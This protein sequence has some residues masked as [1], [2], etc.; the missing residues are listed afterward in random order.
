MQKFALY[1]ALALCTATKPAAPPKFIYATK[2]EVKQQLAANESEKRKETAKHESLIEKLHGLAIDTRFES[3]MEKEKAKQFKDRLN[4]KETELA[5][6]RSLV[7]T[8]A[9]SAGSCHAV[10][11]VSWLW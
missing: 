1:C 7:I 6:A 9:S 2:T 11:S 4:Q 10:A 5:Q 3:V 8:P